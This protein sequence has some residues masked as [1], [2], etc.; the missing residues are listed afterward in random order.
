MTAEG[1]VEI[2]IESVAYGGAGVGRIDGKVVFVPASLPG[3]RLLIE[4]TRRKSSFAE[5][6]IVRVL[7]ASPDRVAAPC[8]W[9]GQCGGCAY[10]HVRYEAQPELKRLQVREVLARLGGI[11]DPP[12]EAAVASPQPW[13]YR[14]RITVRAAGGKVGF[15]GRR[16][17]RV[18][19]V[20]ECLL[21]SPAV[22]QEL[23]SLRARQPR[24]GVHTLREPG[25]GRGFRQVNDA[26]AELLAGVVSGMTGSGLPWLVDAY[27]GAGF[28]AS[29][30]AQ[31]FARTVGLEWDARC[32]E[33]QKAPSFEFRLGDVS[34][35]LPPLLD[36]LAASGPGVLLLDPPAQGVSPAVL[37]AVL[38][39]PPARLV[40]VSCDPATLARDLGRLASGFRVQRVVPIDMFPQTASIETAALLLPS[41][42]PGPL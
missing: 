21:A 25:S 40:Y 15:L 7:E 2:S 41:P 12:V 34:T 6:R 20:T 4:L 36:E 8:P 31:R 16:G 9:F 29:R 22:N 42:G 19:D 35:L 23:T 11:K 3:E 24:G 10:Q 17:H 37:R 1:L 18:I 28:F 39:H 26:A 33:G 30:L 38:E 32:L 14:N 13:A 5:G 27:C